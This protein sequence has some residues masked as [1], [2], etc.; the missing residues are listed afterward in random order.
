MPETPVLPPATATTD[1][2]PA[3]IAA[4]RLVATIGL[5]G[6][7]STWVFNV[8][9]ELMVAAFGADRVTSLFAEDAARVAIHEPSRRHTI[10][11]AHR[12]GNGLEALLWMARA[13]IFLSIRDPRD[14]FL[15]MAQRFKVP[16]AQCAAAVAADC[17]F[18]HRWADEGHLTL[19]YEDH[20]YKDPATVLHLAN[21]LGI[22]VAPDVRQAIFDRYRTDTVRAFARTVADLPPDRLVVNPVTMN[23][24]LTQI[25]ATHIGDGQV[26]KWKTLL[27]DRKK[28]DAAA[29]FAPFLK[30][31]G[32]EP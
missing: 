3:S 28:A 7:A 5:H 12:G 8:A 20:F 24:A 26:G 13:P 19:R 29:L 1:E 21:G 4:P 25:H 6:S 10:V 18:V 11:K 30:R 27:D 32:Y 2:T 15:S 16:V 14:A 22:D 23:D 17:G 9:R 31:F